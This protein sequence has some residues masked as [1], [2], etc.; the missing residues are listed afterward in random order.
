MTYYEIY[1]VLVLKFAVLLTGGAR[2]SKLIDE[3]LSTY[4][5]IY[6]RELVL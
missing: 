6:E 4:D 2:L 3:D 1:V 5:S